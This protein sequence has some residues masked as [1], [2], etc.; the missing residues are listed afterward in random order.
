MDKKAIVAV[1]CVVI[2][3]A[4]LGAYFIATQAPQIEQKQSEITVT[5]LAGRTVTIK[6][7]VERVMLPCGDTLVDYVVVEGSEEPLKKIVGMGLSDLKRNRKDFY[8]KYKEKFP[9]IENIPDP[10]SPHGGTFSVEMA[11]SL[12]P[13]V[14][15]LPMWAYERVK[16]DI[17]KLEQAGIPVVVIEYSA[18]NIETHTKSTLLLG[19]L[20][21]KEK[22]AQDI[23]DFYKEQIN[24]VYSRLKEIDKPKPK[25]YIE[26]GFKGTSEYGGTYGSN[27]GGGALVVQCGGINIAE[28]KV[29][30]LGPIN[31][32][33]LLDANPDVIIITGS[34]WPATPGSMR[35]GYYADPKE[36]REL[37][38]AFTKRP[39]WDTLNATKNNRVHSIHHMFPWNIFDFAATQFM[40][41]SFYPEE[42]K[43]LDPEKNLREFHERFLPVNYSG[44][45]MLSLKE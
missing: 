31:P 9:E 24:E 36:S 28:G 34:Y 26:G 43:D 17:S 12:K 33:Y 29:E 13:D 7:P 5:D 8:D 10:G 35:L 20:L 41:K 23:M 42:F 4:A 25:V 37:L 19:K 18:A 32:E 22:R 3:G 14:V 11:I 21:G 38:R 2:L 16:E 30:K 1:I 44:V 15:I 40:A 39:G 45:W 27:Y 6:K